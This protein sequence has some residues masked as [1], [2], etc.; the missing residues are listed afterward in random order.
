MPSA[1]VLVNGE[2][3]GGLKALFRQKRVGFCNEEEVVWLIVLH[4]SSQ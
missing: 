3:G 4:H 1:V 2:A